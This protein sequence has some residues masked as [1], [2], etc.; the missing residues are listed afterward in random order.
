MTSTVSFIDSLFG[1]PNPHEIIKKWKQDMLRE[2]H[3][4]DRNI[5][6]LDLTETKTKIEIRKI[7]KR[8]DT[9]SAKILTKEIVRIRK[10][11]EKLY[12]SKAHLYSILITLRSASAT[13]KMSESLKKSTE[14]M[15][16]MNRAINLPSINKTVMTMAREMEKMGFIEEIITEGV[17]SIDGEEVEQDAEEEI[18]KVLDE[19]T[20]S[21]P[22]ASKDKL[23]DDFE[24]VGVV[25]EDSLNERLTALKS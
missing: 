14:V 17:E 25:Q 24:K 16:A 2:Q 6:A 4:L 10:A 23:P 13:M 1:R 20:K 12:I 7:M 19:I 11:K 22:S 21:I 8:K 15:A 3:A 18:N 9:A 5:R